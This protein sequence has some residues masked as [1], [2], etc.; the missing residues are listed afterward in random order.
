[1]VDEK[2]LE[3]DKILSFEP[4]KE[5]VMFGGGCFVCILP[6]TEG[7]PFSLFGGVCA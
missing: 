6:L 3:M 1:V 7:L 2:D 5:F 4:M